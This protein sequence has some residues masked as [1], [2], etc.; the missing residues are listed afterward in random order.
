MP[1]QSVNDFLTQLDKI[2]KSGN[3]AESKSNTIKLLQAGDK[4]L[5][6]RP[7]L[8]KLIEENKLR[9]KISGKSY[10]KEEYNGKQYQR[11]V[12]DLVQQGGTM[13]GIAL[14]GYTY[15]MERAGV[16][17]RS[18]AG[19]SAGA[20][21]TL[22]LSALPEEIYKDGSPFIE[23]K[24][25][26]KSEFLAYLVA[27]KN[28][29]D[30]L[31]R[32]RDFVGWLQAKLVKR[33]AMIGKILPK[34]L[35][36]LPL[37][38]LGISFGL[39]TLI[40]SNLFTLAN[41]LKEK[42]IRVYDFITGTLGITAIFLFMLL[43]IF[44]LFK[45]T[46]GVNPG[47]VV[48]G[49][50]TSILQ[51]DYVGINT[52]AELKARKKKII[53]SG[54]EDDPLPFSDPGIVI[55]A[56]NLTHNRI[57]KFPENNKDYWHDVYVDL[58]SP[59]TYVRASMS[60]PFIFYAFI[61]RDK[62]IYKMD[63]LKKSMPGDGYNPEDTTSLHKLARFV[64]GGMLSNFPIREFHVPPASAPRY[65]T[66]GVLLGSGLLEAKEENKETT[67]LKFWSESVFKY[68]LSFIST[69]RNFYDKDFVLT[70]PEF[71]QLV[72][73]VDTKRFNSLDFGMD[74]NTKIELFEEGAKAA[75][76][77]LEAFDWDTYVKPRIA[78]AKKA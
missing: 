2:N 58:V 72:Q 24:Q 53:V 40:N 22:L 69:F 17:F 54:Y 45:H 35:I 67:K 59:A 32:R 4:L 74:L 50:L 56:A 43:L 28:F 55:I 11:P 49:W 65:P 61:P 13:L 68:I 66:F 12:I 20:I 62:H 52:T 14:L 77:Q 23:G 57:V 63:Q 64:D 19:T 37:I 10:I 5:D 39:Y 16:R 47:E 75:I 30:F 44:R 76:K 31:D 78:E 41:G 46:M 8:K 73:A 21:N 27:N 9:P 51:T 71:S 33:V 34:F 38:L 7:E 6:A 25:A 48:Y 36:I 60:L 3:T 42:E 70:H 18:M 15:T 29:A 26:V 1:S